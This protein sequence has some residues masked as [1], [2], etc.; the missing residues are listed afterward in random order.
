[1]F[2]SRTMRYHVFY[3]KVG[4]T[5]EVVVLTEMNSQNTKHKKT[6]KTKKN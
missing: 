6:K 1:M 3:R 2:F 4:M 5:K